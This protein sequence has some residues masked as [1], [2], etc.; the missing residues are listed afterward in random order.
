MGQIR[1]L[2]LDFSFTGIRLRLIFTFRK[3]IKVSFHS[4]LSD[5]LDFKIPLLR[6]MALVMTRFTSL[7]DRNF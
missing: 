6:Q 7:I 1:F 4:S 3:V 5:T 2:K